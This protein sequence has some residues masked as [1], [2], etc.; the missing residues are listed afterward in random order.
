MHIWRFKLVMACLPLTMQGSLP[1]LGFDPN[2]TIS[3]VKFPNLKA[4]NRLL[5]V[6]F[7][8]SM[9]VIDRVRAKYTYGPSAFPIQSVTTHE[10]LLGW[11][12]RAPC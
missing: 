4:P 11:T 6:C 3:S 5:G 8:L 2:R 1:F 10:Y 7:E 9:I 12:T